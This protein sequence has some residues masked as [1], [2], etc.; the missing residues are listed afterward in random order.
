MR[1]TCPVGCSVVQVSR[2]AH[3]L[4]TGAS[5]R[6][7]P[8]GRL[9]GDWRR[10]LLIVLACLD[11]GVVTFS[12]VIAFLARFATAEQSFAEVREAGLLYVISMAVLIVGWLVALVVN[13]TYHIESLAI[14]SDEY[15]GVV[16]ATFATFG[17]FA[18]I[19][20]LM[21]WQVAR[22]FLAVALPLG[23]FL[24][25]VERLLVRRW[26]LR[27][28]QHSMLVDGAIVIG[29]PQEV[30]YAAEAIARNPAAG[31][32]VRAVATDAEA[33][34]FELANGVVVPE[35]GPIADVVDAVHRYRATTIIVAGHN[36]VNRKQ[37]RQLGWQLE[38]TPI[39]LALA[40]RMTDVAGPRIHWR[41]VEGLPLMNVAMP[42]YS[43]VKYTLKRLF[44]F[45]VAG[46]MVL[47]LAPVLLAVALWVKLDSTGPVFFRQTRVGVN[48]TLF[49]MTKFR[50]MVVDAEARLAELERQNEGSGLLFKMKDDPR[51]TRAGGFIRRYSLDELPQ[52]FDVL[53]GSMS[54]VGPRPPLP[55]EVEAYDNHVHRRLNVKPGITGPWQVGGRSNLSWEES[56]RKDLYYVENW[57]LS[58]DV[59][60]MFK[61]VRAVLARDGAF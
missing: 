26:L 60:I 50:S 61:T 2:G 25:L 41:P 37:L 30:R 31:L 22:G 42:R 18:I 16:R 23:L 29:S 38:D 4:V 59:V 35:A 15:R 10:N 58:G 46:G 5:A 45:V 21:R 43:G 24:L 51:I 7:G 32:V 55:H 40:S 39:K 14:G 28:R 54:L 53:R 6:T 47:M 3:S 44:D 19:M 48:G 57:S 56:V 1:I 12:L 52:L 8:L 11:L 27:Q 9:R 34:T 13:Q 17:A 20:T 33:P 49:K 36:R